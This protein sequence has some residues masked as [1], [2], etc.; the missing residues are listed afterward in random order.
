MLSSAEIQ[1]YFFYKLYLLAKNDPIT[2]CILS[3]IN[4]ILLII[5]IPKLKKY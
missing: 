1:Q 2:V 5:F 4:I 3:I